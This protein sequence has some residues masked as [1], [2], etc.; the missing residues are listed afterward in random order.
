MVLA[1]K[2]PASS[3]STAEPH[4]PPPVYGAVA[5]TACLGPAPDTERPGPAYSR[6]G[7][8]KTTAPAPSKSLVSQFPGQSGLQTGRCRTAAGFPRH[9]PENAYKSAAANRVCDPE[10]P[11]SKAL[12]P[13]PHSKRCTGE[14][15]TVEPGPP[16]FAWQWSN[17]RKDSGGLHPRPVR[18]PGSHRVIP[19]FFLFC[20]A[21]AKRLKTAAADWD[22]G[23]IRM[24]SSGKKGVNPATG[25]GFC[26][27]RL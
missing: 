12:L 23:G 25:T 1:P 17:L 3:I 11:G 14:P 4:C 2:T 6:P 16:P 24:S 20:Q 19:G 21:V 13:L 22:S 18:I 27:Q 7:S 9:Q 10:S 15:S 26:T 5:K 8:L